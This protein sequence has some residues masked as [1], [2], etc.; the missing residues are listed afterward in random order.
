MSGQT[1]LKEIRYTGN[2]NASLEP[3][4]VL[5]FFY[6]RKADEN[7]SFFQGL[8]VPDVLQNGNHAQI[9][10]WRRERSLGVTGLTGMIS[11]SLLFI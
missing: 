2:E 7:E 5:R 9:E 8:A 6:E 1:F 10:S 4:N 3:Y 11:C